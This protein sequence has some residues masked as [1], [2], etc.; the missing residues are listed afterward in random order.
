M[1]EIIGLIAVRM[2][3]T[4]LPGKAFKMLNGKPLIEVLIERLNQTPHLDDFVVC[5]TKKSSDDIIEQFC[6]ECNINVYRGAGDNVLGRF[7]EASATIPSEYVVRI[8]GDN[9]LTDFESMNESFEYLKEHKG[10]YSRPIGVPGGAACEIIRTKALLEV[11]ART[12][13][14]ELSEYMTFF[15][16]IAPFVK[17][18][19]FKVGEDSFLP[20][21]R[22]TVDYEKDLLFL[23]EL[24]SHFAGRYPSLSEIIRYCRVSGDYPRYCNDNKTVSKIREKIRF[25]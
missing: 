1:K 24:L 9:P 16:E 19:L 5:T 15:F 12:L 18:S 13:S 22:L 20:D 8:T 4:R 17:K 21:L 14:A 25:V 23:N 11:N 6:L 7:V 10:D 3:S 2:D